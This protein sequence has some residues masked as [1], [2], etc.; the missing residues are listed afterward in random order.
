[1]SSQ[2]RPN[3]CGRDFDSVEQFRHHVERRHPRTGWRW[4]VAV[5]GPARDLKFAR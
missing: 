4:W 3:A 1:M 5:E 2:H